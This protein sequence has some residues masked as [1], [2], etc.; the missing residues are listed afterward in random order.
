LPRTDFLK[1]AVKTMT[2]SPAS[3][4]AAPSLGRPSMSSSCWDSKAITIVRGRTNFEMLK[5]IYRGSWFTL[6][7]GPVLDTGKMWIGGDMFLVDAGAALRFRILGKLHG[8]DLRG[9]KG[10]FY[11]YPV[12]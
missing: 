8:R 12:R 1:R 10:M 9:G 3:V 4:L 2:P 6:D 5:R 7:A 11:S